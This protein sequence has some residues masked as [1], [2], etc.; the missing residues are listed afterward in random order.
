[1]PA[2]GAPVRVDGKDVGRITSAVVS[3]AL[4]VALALGFLKREY[5]EPGTR[6]EVSGGDEPLA[7]SLSAEVAALPFYSRAPAA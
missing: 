2:A 4:G 6:V 5:Q 1:M 7:A 3:P